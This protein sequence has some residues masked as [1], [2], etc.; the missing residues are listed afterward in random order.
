MTED[1]R[2]LDEDESRAWR[3]IIDMHEGLAEFLDRRLRTDSGLSTAD[4]R[5]LVHLSEAPD[6]RLRPRALQQLLHWEKGRLS[7]HLTRMEGRG[8]VTREPC[9][10]DLRGSVTA[11]TPRGREL[12]GTAAARHVAVV[13]AAVVD[14]LSREEL[15]V[16]AG[17][18][19]RVRQQVAA[20]EA[21][22]DRA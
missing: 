5:V 7:Q 17:L 1:P 14:L 10:D 16:L 2:W 3:S 4:Y 9:A 8:L 20:L 19:E 11:I 22:R 13:R 18:S 6:G 12:I 15:A 21:E